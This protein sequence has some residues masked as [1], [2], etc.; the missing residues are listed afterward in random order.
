LVA[1]FQWHTM[2]RG[3]ACQRSHIGLL[4]V[5]PQ[6]PFFPSF[7]C[8]YC[9]VHQWVNWSSSRKLFHLWLWV[10]TKH[11]VC[12]EGTYLIYWF[13]YPCNSSVPCYC[14]DGRWIVKLWMPH[15]KLQDKG[16]ILFLI[17]QESFIRNDLQRRMRLHC[18]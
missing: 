17:K 11:C 8:G 7:A 4:L 18:G 2:D 5:L 1:I 15:V 14:N 13:G 10:M 6:Y 12:T 16:S 3:L 9:E